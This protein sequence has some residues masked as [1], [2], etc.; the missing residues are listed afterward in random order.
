MNRDTF[1]SNSYRGDYIQGCHDRDESREIIK[2]HSMP[3]REFKSLHAAKCAISLKIADEARVAR[4]AGLQ[5]WKYRG[6][7][8]YPYERNSSGIRWYARTASGMLRADS[9]QM[10]RFAINELAVADR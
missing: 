4:E 9:K 6:V 7:D 10:M 3:G 8:V 5:P 1:W 2:V